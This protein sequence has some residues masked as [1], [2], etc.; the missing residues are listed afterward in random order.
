VA[1]INGELLDAR[2]VAPF[3]PPRGRPINA[4]AIRWLIRT[5]NAGLTTL[6]ATSGISIE[7]TACCRDAAK[8]G[9]DADRG[10]AAAGVRDAITRADGANVHRRG[11]RLLR[12]GGIE[13]RRRRFDA[14]PMRRRM[15]ALRRRRLLPRAADGR[16]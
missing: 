4:S 14:G 15:K 5:L 11:R 10:A 1:A 2:E 7:D 8:R 13:P 9:H 12:T 16:A 6:F 3:R